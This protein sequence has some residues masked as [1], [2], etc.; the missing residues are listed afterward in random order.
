MELIIVSIGALAKHAIWGEKIAMRTSHATTTLI[1]TGDKNILIDPSLPAQALGARLEERSG[2]KPQQITHVFLTNWR[3]VHRRAIELFG[4]AQWLMHE[5]EI[6]AANAA[7]ENAI[8]IAH[9]QN[10]P[11]DDIITNEQALLKRVQAAPDELADGVDLFPLTGYTPGQCGM[12]I[13]EPTL[14]TII[15]GD[16]VP[17]AAHF[18]AGQVFGDCY[19]LAKA[20]ESLS[21]LY[22]VADMIVPGHDNIFLARRS[23]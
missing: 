6:A 15:A 21:E 23:G 4:A 7:L 12:L 18:S 19:D 13:A 22:E 1:K 3:P 16:A 5:E 9:R 14:T 20:K 10:Q 17:T 11:V 8:D 2:L